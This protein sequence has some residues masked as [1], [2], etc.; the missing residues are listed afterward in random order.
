MF[1]L[2]SLLSDLGGQVGLWLGLSVL[3]LFEIV[4]LLTDVITLCFFNCLYFNKKNIR[5]STAVE[6]I[7]IAD[8]PISHDKNMK[9]ERTKSMFEEME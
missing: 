5:P 4:E 9:M 3:T 8:L 7:D 1:Q 6:K 2:V